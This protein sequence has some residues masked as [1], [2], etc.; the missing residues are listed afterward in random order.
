[1]SKPDRR[2]VIAGAAATAAL[3]AAPLPLAARTWNREIAARAGDK[4]TC[5]NG[6]EI[7]TVL[8]DIAWDDIHYGRKLGRW[9]GNAL[10]PAKVGMDAA[11][12]ICTACGERWYQPECAAPIAHQYPAVVCINGERMPRV[13]PE[14]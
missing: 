14:T 5:Q 1:M 2:T 3:A 6:H 8:R 13:R 4:V 9:T 10:V 7:A 12:C 11:K